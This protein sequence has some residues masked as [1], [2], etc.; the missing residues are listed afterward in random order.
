V[1]A[2]DRALELMLAGALCNSSS[3][4]IVLA[5]AANCLLPVRVFITGRKATSCTG[6]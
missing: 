6:S 4:S 5:T 1:S 3:S 2:E